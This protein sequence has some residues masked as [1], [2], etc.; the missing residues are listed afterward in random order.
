MTCSPGNGYRMPLHG[1]LRWWWWW[2]EPSWGATQGALCVD[3]LISH[4]FFWHTSA[5]MPK[6]RSLE[7]GI[8]LS[9]SPGR[10][11]KTEDGGG[12]VRM[13]AA[14]SGFL[15]L[16]TRLLVILWNCQ[17]S[18]CGHSCGCQAQRALG[19]KQMHCPVPLPTHPSLAANLCNQTLLST[20]QDSWISGCRCRCKGVTLCL[21]AIHAG[22]DP[23]H[24]P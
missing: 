21:A 23:Y 8:L 12:D 22:R 10:K 6:S 17:A 16:E 13:G 1:Q 9:P 20:K 5:W 7:G 4:P 15:S 3:C 2:A 11:Q 14:I 18:R 24:A 19:A